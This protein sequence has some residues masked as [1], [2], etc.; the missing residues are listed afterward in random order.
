MS[1]LGWSSILVLGHLLVNN[2]RIW[3]HIL[4]QSWAFSEN[5]AL[6]SAHSTHFSPINATNSMFSFSW[7]WFPITWVFMI[8]AL[9]GPSVLIS[10]PH[11]VLNFF[12][13][14]KDGLES[15]FRMFFFWKCWPE[16]PKCFFPDHLV[17]AVIWSSKKDKRNRF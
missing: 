9:S 4:N 11:F 1:P 6:L 8:S 13:L 14:F 7:L 17:V 15:C 3:H 12:I 2:L 16:T 10:F 5:L